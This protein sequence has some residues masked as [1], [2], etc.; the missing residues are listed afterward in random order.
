[1]DFDVTSDISDSS[2]DV[3]DDIDSSNFDFDFSDNSFD[4][5]DDTFDDIETSDVDDMTEDFSN[6]FD[7]VEDI[8]EDDFNED[9]ETL[10]LDD[11]LND[12]EDISEDDFDEDIETLD[13]DDDIDDMVD[14]SEDDF[15]EDIETLDLDDDIDDMVDISEDDFDEDIETLDLDDDLNDME[16]ISENDFDE[17]ID[18]LD[19]DD[20]FKEN[21]ESPELNDAMEENFDG[22][23]PEA[24]DDSDF[25]TA[26]IEP[27]E[28]E[29][30]SENETLDEFEIGDDQL[31]EEVG[32]ISTVEA[33][34]YTD[35]MENENISNELEE[36]FSDSTDEIA[37]SDDI[38]EEL[39][40]NLNEYDVAPT[41]TKEYSDDTETQEMPQITDEELEEFVNWEHEHDNGYYDIIEDIQNDSNLT[42]EQKDDLI[43]P[44]LEE[45]QEAENAEPEYGAR[46]KGLTYDGRDIHTSKPE[47]VVDEAPDY[48]DE[49]DYEFESTLNG[50]EEQMS[51]SG[52]IPEYTDIDQQ[53]EIS[54]INEDFS[55]E[56]SE[57]DYDSIYEGLDDYDF[58]EIDC[59]EDTERLDASLEN[60]TS[61]NWEN[62]SIDEQKEQM[63]DLAQ[64]IIDVTG[65]EDPPKIEF[66]NNPEEGDY[67]GF[68]RATNTLSINEHMLYQN[69]EA[70]DTVAH[71]LWHAYQYERAS[72]PKSKLD[73]MY[74]EN[75]NDY[76]T[77]NDDFE[78][79]Q[80]QLLES[81]ARAFA[82]Q[83]KDR[84]HSYR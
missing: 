73:Y 83:I 53:E 27:L 42:D 47:D 31:T 21:A 52:D 35:E 55:G 29:N 72:N 66:Y 48:L 22:I 38:N 54:D 18:T 59:L 77:P 9:I 43:Q 71:E 12:I 67:G 79:Y 57:Q 39:D 24:I 80:S 75:F 56:L 58:H 2:S 44:M 64:Y 26:E 5:S 19:L 34:D 76:I 16:D 82:Q 30:I 14:I 15:N 63:T 33:N 50:F 49:S 84:L 11:D 60:F 37:V 32:D 13:L 78:G 69:D 40:D 61:E 10:D 46:V 28:T 36:N 20:G 4:I 45:L 17:D 25:E 70:A 3:T 6:D 74:L 62:L 68:N 65:L 51:N 81:E 1:M 7:S 23:S 41:D 8:S